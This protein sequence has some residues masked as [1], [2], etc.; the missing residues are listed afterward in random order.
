[1]YL[2]SSPQYDLIIVGAGV[3]GSSIAHALSTLPRRT[4]PLRIA[5]IERSIAEPERIV[6]ELLQPRGV[7]TLCQLGLEACI[8]GIDAVPVKGYCVVIGGKS[9]HIPYP[10]SHEG[11]SFHHG[12]FIMKLREAAH[13]AHGVDVIE[14]TVTELI[15][16]QQT[17]SVVGVHTSRNGRGVETVHAKL[18]IVADGCFSNL[19]SMVMENSSVVPTT[20]SYCIGLLLRDA[21]LPIHQHGTIIFIKGF[22]PVALYQISESETRMLIDVRLPLPC[23][24]KS[25]I[26]TTVL[27]HL[28]SSLHL[29]VITALEKGR[30]RRMPNS[31]LPSLRQGLKKGVI[32][33]GDAWNMRH[34]LTGGGMTVALGDVLLL[35]RLLQPINDF[36]NW[37][38][39]ERAIK[40]WHWS[41]K[42]LSSTIN[43]LSSALYDLSCAN[44]EELSV[45]C[46]GCFKYFER[47]GECVN[48]PISLLSG[49]SPSPMLLVS[50]FLSVAFYSIWVMFTHPQP[51]QSPESTAAY[52][53]PTTASLHQY[54]SLCLKA[55]RVVRLEIPS[56][57]P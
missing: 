18:V 39:V 54:P 30:L 1:M 40:R 53:R 3:A 21:T 26:I 7:E 34:P 2:G 6:G 8:D 16:D 24:L 23:D 42:P 28:P 17:G 14:A 27:P 5:L 4:K 32:M 50:H 57:H 35:R 29:P 49:V 20:K 12:R 15:E 25:Y 22:G 33:V 55:I 31:F 44:N 11:R 41:R 52:Q 47:G 45:L 13:K 37:K 19:R 48:G 46:T 51:V 10:G 9:V 56:Y 43:I 36:G 38:D